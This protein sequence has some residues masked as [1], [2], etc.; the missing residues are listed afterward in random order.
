MRLDSGE[1]E[2]M[3]VHAGRRRTLGRWEGRVFLSVGRALYLGPAGDTTPHAHHA[4]QVS[5]GLD[6]PFRMRRGRE[7]WREYDGTIVAPDTPHQLDGGWGNLA[8]F[9]VEPESDDGHRWL[10]PKGEIRTLPSGS[11]SA[12]R[13]L[14]RT[15][16]RRPVGGE[17]ASRIPV[18]FLES[19]GLGFDLVTPSDHRVVNAVRKLRGTSSGQDSMGEIARAVGLSPSRL[20]HLFRREMGISAQSY[21]SWVR[22]YQAC[23]ALAG[24]SSLSAASVGAGFSDAAHFTRTFR[25]TFGLAPSQIDGALTLTAGGSLPHR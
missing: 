9:Y 21:R 5:I 8:L 2:G 7:E 10:A 22:I 24:G 15:L 11:V 6:T 1:S 3:T 19:L 23:A 25:R 4:I 17:N 13:A 20:R 16:A 18:D 14:A 12:V